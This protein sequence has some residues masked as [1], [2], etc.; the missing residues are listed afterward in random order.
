M[1]TGRLNLFT[2]DESY[3]ASCTLTEC[4][5]TGNKHKER[6]NVCHSRKKPSRHTDRQ[7]GRLCGL[8]LRLA[9]L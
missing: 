6:Q 5:L 8:T 7:A 2:H 3:M 1:K 9:K 4:M